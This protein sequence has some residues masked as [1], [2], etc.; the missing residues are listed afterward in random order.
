MGYLDTTIT[1]R[2]ISILAGHYLKDKGI[3]P[4][5]RCTYVVCEYDRVGEKPDA[6]GFSCSSTQLIEVK[7]SRADF[8]A[9]RK[10][11]WRKNQEKGIGRYRSYLCP[12]GLIKPDEV[13][14]NWG[15]LYFNDQ[16]NIIP[17]LKPKEQ[18]P[19]HMQELALIASILRR[20]N[21]KKGILHY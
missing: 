16:G 4:F 1:H 2:D 12:E 8:F 21:I 17:V 19:D 13:P 15:L 3:Q 5:H 20:E 7:M 10:K 14:Q 9:D 6:F 11:N 18:I